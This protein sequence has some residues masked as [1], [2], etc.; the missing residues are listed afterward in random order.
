MSTDRASIL[1]DQRL[2]RGVVLVACFLLAMYVLGWVYPVLIVV[3]AGTLLGVFLNGLAAPLGRKSRLPYKAILAA[4]VIL[5]LVAIWLACWLIGP[6]VTKQLEQ[7]ASSVPGALA[8]LRQLGERVPLLRTVLQATPKANDIVTTT[9]NIVQVGTAAVAGIVIAIVIGIYGAFDPGAYERTLLLLI[10]KPRRPRAREIL[11]RMAHVL[12]RWVIGRVILM[13]FVG[14]LTAFGLWISKVP[15]AAAL[16]LLAGVMTF[17]PYL[18]LL[19]SIIP[20]ILVALS[21]GPWSV[22]WVIVVFAI[23]HS[24][25]GYV[26]SP[27][28]ARRTVEFPP[29]CSIAA[30]LFLGTI[31]GVLGF[32]FA[33]PIAVIA[34]ML[35]R[36][37]YVEDVL[38]EPEEQWL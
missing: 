3:F 33:T 27:L 19:L 2:V 22:V 8:R 28:I 36:T 26:L 6:P 10:P 5:L 24:L 23:A 37:L 25:E 31:W 21:K 29:I 32:A 30:Q 17:V 7:L 4:L 18:G 20:A 34:V 14:V 38:G 11:H 16:G 15:L 9:A 12:M 13:V 1:L 35:V